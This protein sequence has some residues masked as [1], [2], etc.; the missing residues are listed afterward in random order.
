[1]S[2]TLSYTL[3]L[4]AGGGR[5]HFRDSVERVSSQAVAMAAANLDP[6]TPDLVIQVDILDP[7]TLTPRAASLLLGILLK[8]ANDRSIDLSDAEL[9]HDHR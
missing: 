2:S 6:A 7:P 5:D 8:A 9:G 1:M 3:S 4:K